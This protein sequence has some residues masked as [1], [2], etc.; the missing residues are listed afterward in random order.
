MNT[1]NPHDR[2]TKTNGSCDCEH[3]KVLDFV[4]LGRCKRKYVFQPVFFISS[5]QGYR[6]TFLEETEE[7]A[8]HNDAE[9][10]AVHINA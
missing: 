2:E 5:A 1:I 6:G 10:I 7:I 9:Y 8:L 3:A 4:A